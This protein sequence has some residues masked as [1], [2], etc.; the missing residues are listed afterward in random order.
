[1]VGEAVEEVETPPSL[2]ADV[3]EPPALVAL[4][5]ERGVDVRVQRLA[6]ADFVIGPL[7]LERKAVTDFHASVINKRLFEQLGRLR[8]TYPPPVG[9]VLEG[10]LAFFEERRQPRAM[11]GALSAVALDFGVSILPTPSREST[12]DLLTVLARRIARSGPPG[13]HDVRF[14]PRTATQQDAQKFAVQGLPGI[15]N[16]VSESLLEQFGS[17]RRLFAA[18]ERELLRAPGVGAR[19]AREIT[20]FLDRPYEGKQRRLG[21]DP[22]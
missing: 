14:K 11:W 2:V 4:L 17:V 7:A 8:D 21:A 18:Q 6:P 5:R 20:E 3:N 16:V 22:E 9:L 15:G 19:R 12:A 10:D 13:T 1:M